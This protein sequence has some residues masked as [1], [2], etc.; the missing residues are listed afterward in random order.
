[1]HAKFI[2]MILPLPSFFEIDLPSDEEPTI[3]PVKIMPQTIT[4]PIFQGASVC[5]D[6]S[7]RRFH[8]GYAWHIEVL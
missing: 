4:C 5:H 6:R 8:H 7:L 2:K 3:F 1:M